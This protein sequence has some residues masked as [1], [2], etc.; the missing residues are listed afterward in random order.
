MPYCRPEFL[1]VGATAPLGAFKLS[2]EALDV[3][4]TRIPCLGSV[5]VDSCLQRC[6]RFPLPRRAPQAQNLL[7]ARVYGPNSINFLKIEAQYSKFYSVFSTYSFHVKSPPFSLCL[8]LQNVLYIYKQK[9]KI[10]EYL[11]NRNKK[12][13][14]NEEYKI[15]IKHKINIK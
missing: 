10:I 4:A 6:C 7:G 14:I 9:L 12:Y 11:R 8:R 3:D 2:R 1:K 13:Y 15:N 5:A